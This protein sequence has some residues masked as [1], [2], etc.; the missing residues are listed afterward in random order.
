MVRGGERPDRLVCLEKFINSTTGGKSC[1]KTLKLGHIN[2]PSAK[3][4]QLLMSWRNW[5]RF[6]DEIIISYFKVAKN[7]R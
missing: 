5:E 6:K 1:L 2:G 3:S 7:S 4:K